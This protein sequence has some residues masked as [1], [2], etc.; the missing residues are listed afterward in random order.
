LQIFVD[1]ISEE[2]I[3][4]IF[5][6]KSLIQVLANLMYSSTAQPD[7][8]GNCNDQMSTTSALSENLTTKE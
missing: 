1:S 5:E 6:P 2:K 8:T 4:T 3:G 7:D